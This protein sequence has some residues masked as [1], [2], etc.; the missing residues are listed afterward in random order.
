VAIPLHHLHKL[1]IIYIPINNLMTSSNH[2]IIILVVIIILIT[3]AI[4]IIILCSDKV[5]VA[6]LIFML[7]ILLTAL[8]FNHILQFVEE[9]LIHSTS[10]YHVVNVLII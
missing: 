6:I 4:L 9:L 1:F 3:V 5:Q 8:V 7:N 10:V 2:V